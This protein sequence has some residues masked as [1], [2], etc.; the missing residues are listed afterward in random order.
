MQ[1]SAEGAM[2]LGMYALM[3]LGGLFFIIYGMA[4]GEPLFG[5]LWALF[6]AFVVWVVHGVVKLLYGFVRT[7][8]MKKSS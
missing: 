7:R 6:I 2:R 3:I 1:I 4:T 5:F 8:L